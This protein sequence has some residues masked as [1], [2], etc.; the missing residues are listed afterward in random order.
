MFCLSVCSVPE[1]LSEKTRRCVEVLAVLIY[2]HFH[3]RGCF[4]SKRNEYFSMVWQWWPS[5]L[6]KGAVMA[7]SEQGRYD[8]KRRTSFQCFYPSRDFSVKSPDKQKKVITHIL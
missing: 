8:E 7:K 4:Y 5:Q 1:C 6:D 3:L 2:G